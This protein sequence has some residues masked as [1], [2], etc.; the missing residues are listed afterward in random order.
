ML[1]TLSILLMLVKVYLFLHEQKLKPIVM[2]PVI[3]RWTFL[4]FN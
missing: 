4:L 2:R 3:Y 1:V